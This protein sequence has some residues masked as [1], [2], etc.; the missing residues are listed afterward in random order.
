MV[1][2]GQEALLSELLLARWLL[3]G[4]SIHQF[5]KCDARDSGDTCPDTQMDREKQH[6]RVVKSTNE[7]RCWV[8]IP[9]QR[10][11]EERDRGAKAENSI[12]L[13]S[14]TKSVILAVEL[15][16]PSFCNL[17]NGNNWLNRGNKYK[18]RMY[19]INTITVGKRRQKA[20]KQERKQ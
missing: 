18:G 19:L 2:G 5:H 12:S 7:T 10:L 14:L 9:E 17:Y 1:I 15:S 3:K 8:H 4:F 6:S 13:C 11:R 20:E 16:V